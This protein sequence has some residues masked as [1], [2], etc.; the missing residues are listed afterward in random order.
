MAVM[1]VHWKVDWM[2]DL[3]GMKMVVMR[4][5]LKGSTMVVQMAPPMV[6]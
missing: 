6:V 5:F 1:L 4:V 2:A 3:M